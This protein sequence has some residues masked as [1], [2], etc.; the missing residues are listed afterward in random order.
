MSGDSSA[1]RPTSKPSLLSLGKA[2][3]GTLISAP[4]GVIS[5]C[6]QVVIG[7]IDQAANLNVFKELGG[8]SRQIV[9]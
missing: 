3:F 7:A 9:D 2:D 8:R 6:P 4:S 5:A 1:L